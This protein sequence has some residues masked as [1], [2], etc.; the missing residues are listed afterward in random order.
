MAT[1]KP[2]ALFGRR[3]KR[4][5]IGDYTSWHLRSGSVTYVIDEFGLG[6]CPSIW[7]GGAEV[8][9]RAVRTIP[10]AIRALERKRA[11]LVKSLAPE[12]R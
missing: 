6:L 2:P 1:P 10:A 5:N 7:I 11:Q 3:M 12:G 8:S 4:F 9:I